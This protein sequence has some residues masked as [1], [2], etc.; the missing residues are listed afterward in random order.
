MEHV[1]T[2]HSELHR[3]S[4]DGWPYT[5]LSTPVPL[6][7]H[8]WPS[9]TRALVSVIVVAYNHERFVRDAIEGVLKQETTFP[10]EFLIHDDAS[11]DATAHIIREYAAQHPVLMRAVLQTENQYS[12]GKGPKGILN[13]LAVGKYLAW[14]DGD[15]FWVDPAKLEIQVKYLESHPDVAVSG[16]NAFNID[17]SGVLLSRSRL[18][19]SEQCDRTAD[20]L[21]SH[22]TWLP[23][24]SMVFRN[25]LRGETIPE[26]RYINNGDTFTLSRLG[27][28]GGSKYHPEIRPSAYR[29]HAGNAWSSK[30]HK[31]RASLAASSYIGMYHYWKR[32]GN[33]E[34]A[35]KWYE[36]WCREALEHVTVTELLL[37]IR[38]RIV[39]DMREIAERRLPISLVRAY[40]TIRNRLQPGRLGH[41]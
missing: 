15:D 1:V 26:V 6:S 30:S 4:S 16:H 39:A 19:S 5:P 14:C 9:G 7:Q 32:V 13:Q 21:M 40:R 36:A 34:A 38:R 28:F 23:A 41:P 18:P 37:L 20:H 22:S 33:L 11:T 3:S 27:R 2:E 24:S 25:V 29:I 31:D 12:Q 10:V 17:A 35:E 8:E